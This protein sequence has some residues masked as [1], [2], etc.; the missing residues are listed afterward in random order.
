MLND[1]YDLVSCD[2]FL[3]SAFSH[4]LIKLVL[5]AKDFGQAGGACDKDRRVSPISRA[6]GRGHLFLWK[7]ILGWTPVL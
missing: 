3:V 2:C 1:D 7:S 5:L 6:L 4:F